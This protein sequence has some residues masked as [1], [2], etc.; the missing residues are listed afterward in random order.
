MAKKKNK[1]NYYDKMVSKKKKQNTVVMP[2]ETKP[3]EEQIQKKIESMR[4]S[5]DMKGKVI[6]VLLSKENY[7][8][9]VQIDIKRVR[10]ALTT[11]TRRFRVIEEQNEYHIFEDGRNGK[12]KTLWS[13][14]VF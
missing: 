14:R 12:Q 7:E 9:D 4:R 6:K 5:N 10:Q 11:L 13:K 2:A 8:Q 1:N 3:T